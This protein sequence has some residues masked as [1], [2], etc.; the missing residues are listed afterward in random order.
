MNIGVKEIF[1]RVFKSNCRQTLYIEMTNINISPDLLEI[2]IQ[3]M[4]QYSILHTSNYRIDEENRY[5]YMPLN[6]CGDG[7]FSAEYNFTAE[8]QYSVKIK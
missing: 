1:P 6:N 5:P 2:K 3:P 4:E 7:L 8:Q